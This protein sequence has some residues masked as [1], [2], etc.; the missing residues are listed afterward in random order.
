MI[1]VS[2]WGPSPSLHQQH[3]PAVTHVVAGTLRQLER[4]LEGV[5][6]SPGHRYLQTGVMHAVLRRIKTSQYQN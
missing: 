2:V 4:M 3:L 6:D 1:L 5:Y